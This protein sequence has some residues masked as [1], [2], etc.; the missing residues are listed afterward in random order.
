[1]AIQT[2]VRVSCGPSLYVMGMLLT[3]NVDAKRLRL[4]ILGTTSTP[5]TSTRA[6]G[7]CRYTDGALLLGRGVRGDKTPRLPAAG[8]WHPMAR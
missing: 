6:D 5:T 7:A 2:K 1:M 3:P 4:S 8:P